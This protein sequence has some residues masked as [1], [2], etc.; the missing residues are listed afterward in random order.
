MDVD[1][2]DGV[3]EAASTGGREPDLVRVATLGAPHG[4]RGDV[5]LSLHTD[6]PGARL[7]VGAAFSTEPAAAGPLRLAAVREQQGRYT[8]RFAG[9]ADRNAAEALRGVVLLTEPDETDD[10]AWYPHQ[11]RGLSAHA[12]DGEHLGTIDGVRHLPAQDVLVLL[13]PDGDR[14][15]VPFVREIVPAVEVSTGR[16]TID[17]PAG[18]LFDEP[19]EEHR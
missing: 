6:D 18:L 3:T 7:R 5:R 15:L 19:E 1:S 9:H 16:V 10:G 4:L 8:A 17:A 14:V 13:K 12:P 11:L 2:H